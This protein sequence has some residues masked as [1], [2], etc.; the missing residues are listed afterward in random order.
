MDL[1]AIIGQSARAA[2]AH[3]SGCV[4]IMPT[5]RLIA[6]CINLSRRPDRLEHMRSQAAAAGFEFTRIEAV[7]GSAPGMEEAARAAAQETGTPPLGTGA[8]AC[9]QSHRACWQALVESG[10][11]H[12]LVLEDDM[13]LAPD[14]GRYLEPDWI[15][16]GAELIRLETFGTRVHL[17]P[18]PAPTTGPRRLHPMR[19]CQLGAG[20]Y[21]LSGATAAALLERTRQIS[22]AVDHVL[23]DIG[24]P[25]YAGHDVLQMT[26]APAIQGK[27]SDPG[28]G[29]WV[30]NSMGQRLL[31]TDDDSAQETFV[32][33]LV[34][35]LKETVRARI[36]NTRYQVVKFG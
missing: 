33:R 16:A 9:F 26:P 32:G 14:F 21:V 19:S 11:S 24:A 6:Y 10:A 1:G 4:P 13:Q 2:V 3:R 8:Y 28:A 35:R 5:D 29:S 22:S 25:S 18:A 36:G 23:F 7:D 34:R 17:D 15:P 27:R 12:A 31:D 30:Q 20:A